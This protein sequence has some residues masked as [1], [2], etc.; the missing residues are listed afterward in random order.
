M[1][2]RQSLLV[3]HVEHQVAAQYEFDDKEETA[4]SL[5]ARMQ[6]DEERVIRRRLEHTRS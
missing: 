2:L 5:E 6:A 1:I 3:L 4:G